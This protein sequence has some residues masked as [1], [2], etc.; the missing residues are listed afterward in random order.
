MSKNISEMTDQELN[1]SVAIEVMGWKSG[2]EYDTDGK[3][4]VWEY[5]AILGHEFPVTKISKLDWDPTHD[6][7]Q[8]YEAEEKIINNYDRTKD[9]PGATCDWYAVRL[10]EMLTPMALSEVSG[11]LSGNK[12]ELLIIHATARQRCEAMLMAVR[13]EK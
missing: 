10:R 13:S 3:W 7:N 5:S 8:C 11:V 9:R 2:H 4:V 12:L 6:L 1:D